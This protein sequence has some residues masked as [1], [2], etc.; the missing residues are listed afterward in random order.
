MVESTLSEKVIENIKLFLHRKVMDQKDLAKALDITPGEV[1][2]ILTGKRKMSLRILEN[3]AEVLNVRLV[4]LL[5]TG[6]SR[7]IRPVDTLEDSRLTPEENQELVRELL[8]IKE[9]FV[10]TILSKRVLR[11]KEPPQI[12]TTDNKVA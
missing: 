5:D 3:I 1:S 11:P 12:L 8:K 6:E 7:A 9:A 2:H 10:L 4:D